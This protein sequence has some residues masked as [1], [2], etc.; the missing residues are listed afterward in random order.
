CRRTPLRFA[1]VTAVQ[2]AA[3]L[4]FSPWLIYAVPKL[5][6]YVGSK[7]ESD[8][9][10]PLGAV[11]YLARHLSAFTAGHISLPALPST[12]VPLLIALVAVVLVAAGLTLGRASQ[13]DR[14][15][16]AGGPTGALWTWL[17]VPL[18]TGWFINLRLPFFPEGGERLLL[19]ILPYFVLL[20][21]VGIDR[22]WSMGHLGKVALAAL[23]VDAGLGIA[24]F[25][26]VPRYAAHDYRPILREIVQD[27][28]NEDTVL[29]IFPWQIG[30]WRAYTPRNAPELDGPR[31]ELLSDAAVVWNREIES[32]IELALERGTVWFPEPLTF[33]S[34]LPE[35]IEAYLE[36]KAANLANRWY[37]ATRLTAWAKLPAPP[38]EVAVADFGPI[39]LRAA[40]VAP[41]VATAENTPV[42]VSLVWEAHTSARLNVSLRLLDNSGQVWSSREYAAAWATTARAGAVVTE[43]VGTIVP[44]GLP[45][46]TYTVAVSL[47]QQNDNGSG[48]A[49]TVAGSDVV[50]APVGHVTVA[51]AEHVQ[52]PVRLPI[53]IQLATP[54]TV[55]GLA[56]LGFTGPDRTEPLLAGTE[57]RVTL[58]L[59]SLTDTPADRTLYVTLQ[60]PNGPG[61]AGYEGWP[62]SGYPVPVLSEGELLRVPV[63]FYVP[64]MLVTGDYQLVVGFQDPDGA[65]KTPPVTLGTVSIRQRKGVFERPLPRQAL[66]VP[67]T[68]GTHV[69][70][71]GYEIEPHISGVANLRL[72]WE[73]VQPLLPPHHIFVHADAADGTTIAQQDGPPS[74]VDGIAPTG[75]WQPGEFLT[76]VHAIE[77]PASTDFFLRVGLYDPA[78]GV[79]LPV[80]IDGQPAGDSIELTMP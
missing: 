9:D 40:G 23:V 70:L 76:T 34:A 71:Y 2:A 42:A 65:N 60:E 61:V 18:V 12:V 74:T 24:A 68:V 72:Y 21:A 49:L 78:T 46:G 50:E 10:T 31:P 57:L 37:D 52:S 3:A 36:S 43:T 66:P 25:Y 63:Q 11:A 1:A 55:R 41:V 54:H 39:Q 48:Q 64:G 16:G 13:P 14:P 20:F 47:E 28:R 58:F 62:L 38:L 22:T 17:L 59:Q 77:L 33:G 53:R 80:T 26:T 75:T 51:A 73:V 5:V 79:R 35:E 15:I 67:A 32:T 56:I 4:I 19:I 30:Y 8:Q 69:R 45:P 29:A 6:G 7:V 44:A 27:G